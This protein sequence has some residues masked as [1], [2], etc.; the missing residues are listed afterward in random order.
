MKYKKHFITLFFPTH[1]YLCV[2]CYVVTTLGCQ[3]YEYTR[4][5]GTK[6]TWR[7]KQT[8]RQTKVF[9]KNQ[10]YSFIWPYSFNW[11]LRVSDEIVRYYWN[12]IAWFQ[13]SKL[14]MIDCYG[15]VHIV[16]FKWVM[17]QSK[18]TSHHH[19]V[20]LFPQGA[21]GSELKNTQNS[22]KYVS[23]KRKKS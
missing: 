21:T 16:I 11:H 23:K 10:P 2:S 17:S 22:D 14:L 13:A 5:F 19:I 15:I 1:I 20:F 4:L 7:K 3:I 8:Q 6:E 18:I 9:N 12:C